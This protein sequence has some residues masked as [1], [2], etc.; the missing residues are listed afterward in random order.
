MGIVSARIAE[1]TIDH[2]TADRIGSKEEIAIA[3][4]V[5]RAVETVKTEI[6]PRAEETVRME[7]AL[8]RDVHKEMIVPRAV[9][10][11]RTEIVPKVEIGVP[12]A[13]ETAGMIVRMAMIAPMGTTAPMA[14]T[15]PMGAGD[16]AEPVAEEICLFRLHQKTNG[17]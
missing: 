9:E 8:V 1:E 13:V 11:V 3:T 10:I 6:V 2:R 14:A 7:T 16:V 17:L 15:A 12:R 4:I 5:L